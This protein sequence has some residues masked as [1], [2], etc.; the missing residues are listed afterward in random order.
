MK[1]LAKLVGIIALVAVIGFSMTACDDGN[2]DGNGDDGGGK[3]LVFQNVP[4]QFYQNFYGATQNGDVRIGLFPVGTTPQQ[5]YNNW[6][7]FVAR[8]SISRISAV[9]PSGGPYTFTM[10]LYADLPA[11]V[12]WNGNGTYDVICIIYS[13]SDTFYF[14]AN[15]VSFS[16]AVTNVPFSM[17]NQ[18]NP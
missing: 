17:V 6:A 7:D 10:P 2:D 11:I 4:A 1:N 3:V 9:G 5:A 14:K 8:V 13:G 16:S 12:Q 18:V 15:S